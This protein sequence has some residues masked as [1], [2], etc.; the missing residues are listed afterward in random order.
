MPTGSNVDGEEEADF[1]NVDTVL[2]L[3][4]DFRDI[5]AIK[6]LSHTATDKINFTVRSLALSSGK[7]CGSVCRALAS[8]AIAL[9]SESNIELLD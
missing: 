5:V 7:G 1:F 3:D 4:E 9:Q 6:N 2:L 8:S